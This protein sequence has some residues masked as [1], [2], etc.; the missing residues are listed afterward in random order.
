MS[1]WNRI[2]I[3]MT[4][5]GERNF[6]QDD[7]Q[8]PLIYQHINLSLPQI[9]KFFIWSWKHQ[10]VTEY[11]CNF[12]GINFIWKSSLLK[13][14]PKTIIY[15]NKSSRPQSDQSDHGRSEIEWT[16]QWL[17]VHQI[18]NMHSSPYT[19]PMTF[20]PPPHKKQQQPNIISRLQTTA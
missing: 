1:L 9:L 12:K 20:K 10:F 19:C 8:T 7:T 13:I 5:T 3:N 4:T 6:V 15:H 14:F 11:K 17:K 2:Q 18:N 16:I